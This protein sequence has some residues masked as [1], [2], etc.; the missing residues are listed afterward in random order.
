MAMFR[1]SEL[2]MSASVD[3]SDIDTFLTNE[4]WAICSTYHTL[5]KASPGPAI[6]GWDVLFD[7]PF[8]AAWNKIGYYRKCQTDLNIN[9]E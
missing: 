9:T 3:T 1:T 8:L 6:F 4:A 5:L 2:N 7:I